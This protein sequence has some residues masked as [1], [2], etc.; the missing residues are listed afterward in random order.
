MNSYR[1]EVRSRHLSYVI[2]DNLS[3]KAFDYEQYIA[4]KSLPDRGRR[5][6]F[7]QV[8]EKLS[9][10]LEEAIELIADLNQIQKKAVSATIVRNKQ[11]EI[12]KG[13]D[14]RVN[15]LQILFNTI[16]DQ[17]EVFLKQCTSLDKKLLKIDLMNIRYGATLLLK[18]ED[19]KRDRAI[20]FENLQDLFN[21]EHM[22][23]KAH[24]VATNDTL[25]SGLDT[26][27]RRQISRVEPVEELIP[28]E[29]G[30]GLLASFGSMLKKVWGAYWGLNKM[31]FNIAIKPSVTMFKEEL[32]GKTQKPPKNTQPK[33]KDTDEYNFKNI[34][35]R[36]KGDDDWFYPDR[37]DNHTSRGVSPS[38][39]WYNHDARQDDFGRDT[40]NDDFGRDDRYDRDM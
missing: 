22:P 24:I 2:Q 40:R 13:I 9:D 28:R 30:K 7:E 36:Y 11:T 8:K 32:V 34:Y 1:D 4:Q 10:N 38:S 20:S 25:F 16:D 21:N 17:K 27:T 31:Y 33:Q 26:Y 37:Q 39:D 3:R 6:R 5:V 35:T 18:G 12:L 14:H 29:E 15:R 23:I 19:T